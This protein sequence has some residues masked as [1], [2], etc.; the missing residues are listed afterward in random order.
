MAQ[1]ELAHRSNNF[2][3]I[4]IVAATSVLVS[5]HFALAKLPEPLVLQFQTLGGYGVFIFFSISGFLV[6]QSWQRDPSLVRFTYR[7]LLRIW[8]GMLCVLILC[9]FL[10]GPAVTT[11]SLKEYFLN[12]LTW[13]YF[14]T[15][16]F[17]VQPF[18]QGVFPDSAVPYI[19][20][21]VL[22]TIPIE[23]HCYG[24]LAILGVIGVLRWR[25]VLLAATAALAV[26]YYGYHDAENVFRAGGGRVHE[27]EFATFF[28]SGVLLHYFREIWSSWNRIIPS[29][30]VVMTAFLL[31]FQ[32]DHQLIAV[33][34]FTPF[35]F[36]V[37]GN[38]S[39]P[40]MRRF[41]RF[42]D[43]SYGIYIYAFPVQ[44]TLFWLWGESISFNTSLALALTITGLLAWI[45]WHLIEQPALR[46]KPRT[47]KR[48]MAGE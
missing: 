24:Y 45:S 4:R 34:L 40:I 7:R 11:L 35:F 44:Q 20:N 23:V 32:N 10:L 48:I 37:L 17:Q 27:I 16:L 36:V 8:P 15:M 30:L 3:F 1:S 13:T 29:F 41:G 25:W 31:L 38:L 14:K 18:L 21:G 2:D 26:Y 46:L 42:G 39:F 5:H 43:M 22:W 9:A 12:E 6:A 28:F 33:F 47:P 19:P